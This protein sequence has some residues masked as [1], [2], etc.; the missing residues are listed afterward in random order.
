M[1]IHCTHG[2]LW[3][4][5]SGR[6]L[7]CHLLLFV[8]HPGIFRCEVGNAVKGKA[9]SQMMEVRLEPGLFSTFLLSIIDTVVWLFDH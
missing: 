3:E 6:S 1:M 9:V 8:S 5:R 7:F 2:R 4:A